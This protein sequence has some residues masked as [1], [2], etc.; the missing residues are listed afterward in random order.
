ML[1]SW[2]WLSQYVKINIAVE[3]MVGKWAMSGL[4][5][6]STSYV[7]GDPVCDLEVTSNRGDCL[8]HIGIAREASVLLDLPLSIPAPNPK[9][10]ATSVQSILSIENQFEEGCPRYTGRI[11]RGVKVGSSPAWLVRRLNA[12][13]VNSV[14]NVV[15]ATNYVMFECGQ[16]LH[17]FDLRH[18]HG[19][20]II[21][22]PGRDKEN[23]QAIDHRNYVLDSQM[24]VIAD[25][26]RAVAL[27]GVMG[28]V[29]SEVSASTVD[30]LIEA[31]EF[32]PMSVRRTAR[33]LKLHS[34]SSFRYERKVD[35]TQ[36]DWASLRCCQLILETAGGELLS[37][38]VDT[39][40]ELPTRDSIVLRAHQIE[41]ILG[42][43][44][45][46]SASIEILKRLGCQVVTSDAKQVTIVPPSF[47]HD[48]TREADLIEEIARIHGYDKI[49]EDAMVPMVASIKRPKDIYLTTVRNIACAVGFDESLTPSLI[50]KSNVDRISPWTNEEPLT[51]LMPLLEGASS[52]R[53]S[54][55]PSLIAGK[56]HNQSQSN[57]DVQL[58][59][60][61]NVYL[62]SGTELPIEQ[63]N[64][65]LLTDRD[66]RAVRGVFEEIVHRLCGPEWYSTQV[67]D[68]AASC[69]FVEPNSCVQ[70][71]VGKTVLA[72]IGPLNRS[73][74]SS[75]KLDVN[76]SIGELNLDFLFQHSRTV[77]QLKTVVPFPSI[78]RDLNLIVDEALQWQR[79]RSVV[80]QSA[81][82]L[83]TAV[84]FREIYRDTKKDGDGRKRVLLSVTLQSQSETLKSE[85]ADLVIRDVLNACSTQLGAQLLA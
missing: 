11:I 44:I 70:W 9:Q 18:V 73:M 7:N 4:N 62:P 3:D 8:G 32:L 58:F 50:G 36:L 72:W 81:G 64:L 35:R 85:Q 20:K 27:G 14:N 13:G 84:T 12:I 53:R 38:S 59:E 74:T 57:R 34:P 21:V 29:D 42:I 63:L 6:E 30:I 67:V 43:S 10:S 66:Q 46:W 77:P 39:N 48:L 5:H 25:A 19:N 69:D 15:D 56:L 76:L 17:A 68:F 83:C 49:P 22:R 26:D 33:K 79:L 60:I 1:V 41:R 51:T 16:P 23:F 28:G 82:A 61:A 75:L 55:I 24:I 80:T 40:P 37:G 65:G 45:P 31:A 78:E 71:K 47:R 54:L 2:E 52:L